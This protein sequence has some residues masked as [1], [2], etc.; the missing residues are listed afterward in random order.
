MRSQRA[1]NQEHE[2]VLMWRV[3]ATDAAVLLMRFAVEVDP[4]SPILDMAKG[5]QRARERQLKKDRDEGCM[6]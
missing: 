5:W 3:L 4:R 6:P 2:R 1:F